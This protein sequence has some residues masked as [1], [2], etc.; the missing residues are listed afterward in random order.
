M[1]LRELLQEGKIVPHRTSK[2]EISDLFG[3]MERDLHDASIK[4]ISADRRFITAYNVALQGTTVLLHLQGYRTRAEAHHYFTFLAGREI[5]GPKHHAMMDYFNTC[6][7]KR[8]VSDYDRAG[9]IS[10]KEAEALLKETAKF[11][12]FVQQIAESSQIFRPTK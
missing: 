5:L 2:Q 3:I 11:Y 9:M 1:T 7:S 10:D 8:N 6:R 12:R 4:G